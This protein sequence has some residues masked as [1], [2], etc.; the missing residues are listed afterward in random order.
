M[1]D[2]KMCHLFMLWSRPWVY[3]LILD[4]TIKYFCILSKQLS[5][6]Y[7]HCEKNYI[8]ADEM[9]TFPCFLWSPTTWNFLYLLGK[10]INFQLKSSWYNC[11]SVTFLK[12]VCCCFCVYA[13]VFLWILVS[14]TSVKYFYSMVNLSISQ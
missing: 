14:S 13:L 5:W 4:V 8:L 2:Y 12:V 6:K 11:H 7:W 10:K 9:N 1:N 3:I